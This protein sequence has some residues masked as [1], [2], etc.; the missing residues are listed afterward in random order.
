MCQELGQKEIHC[1]IPGEEATLTT[2]SNL[3]QDAPIL[4]AVEQPTN[5][6]LGQSVHET[7]IVASASDYPDL[8]GPLE[9]HKRMT[10]KI[11]LLAA[12]QDYSTN[13]KRDKR[14]PSR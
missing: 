3:A 2:T 1:P 8:Q 10:A 7:M 12:R 14:K 4:L 11:Q 5:T 9:P 6:V 13:S